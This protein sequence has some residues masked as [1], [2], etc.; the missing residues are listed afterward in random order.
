MT[1][2]DVY[3]ETQT[4]TCYKIRT[5]CNNCNL[6]SVF[7]QIFKALSFFMSQARPG[8]TTT[9]KPH[10]ALRTPLVGLHLANHKIHKSI[11]H[12]S[13][14]TFLLKLEI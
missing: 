9:L 2:K 7:I 1:S 14:F 3:N 13:A 11:K 12:M 10:P 4:L 8:Q 5:V 6:I